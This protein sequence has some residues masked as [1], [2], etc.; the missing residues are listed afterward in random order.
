MP[1]PGS[2]PPGPGKEIERDLGEMKEREPGQTQP[3]W[4]RSAPNLNPPMTPLSLGGTPKQGHPP[5]FAALPPHPWSPLSSCPLIQV[6]PSPRDPG[7][8]SIPHRARGDPK[9]PSCT[10]AMGRGVQALANE[11]F[12]N[13]I[14]NKE[15]RR[16]MRSAPKFPHLCPPPATSH[17]G[18]KQIYIEPTPSPYI[19]R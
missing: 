10:A 6:G 1:P 8:L 15:T 9:S 2:A 5:Q 4:A 18:Y 11:T 17:P 7:K 3:G 12:A 19:F 13:E 16:G 14:G